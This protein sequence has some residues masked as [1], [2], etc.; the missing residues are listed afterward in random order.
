MIGLFKSRDL[1]FD[2]KFA[3][4]SVTEVFEQLIVVV[5]Y[6]FKSGYYRVTEYLRFVPLLFV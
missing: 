1:P 4:G 5:S 2:V 3:G 6:I